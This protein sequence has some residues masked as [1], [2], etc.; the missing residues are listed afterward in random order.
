MIA[1]KHVMSFSNS[2]ASCKNGLQCGN[3]KSKGSALFSSEQFPRYF[4]DIN[5]LFSVMMNHCIVSVANG[6]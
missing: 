6:S 5:T 2:V 3:L 1:N 4:R